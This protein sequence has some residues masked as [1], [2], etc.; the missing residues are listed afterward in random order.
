M[1]NRWDNRRKPGPLYKSLREY[2]ADP[3]W[4]ARA[5]CPARHTPNHEHRHIEAR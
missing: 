5:G 2:L 4:C 1:A 3:V